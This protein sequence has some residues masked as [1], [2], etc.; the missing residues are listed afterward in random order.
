MVLST[1]LA[2][3]LI[4]V[5]PTGDKNATSARKKNCPVGVCSY[6][7]V[8]LE[9]SLRVRFPNGIVVEV[10]VI[11][12]SNNTALAQRHEREEKCYN[13]IPSRWDELFSQRKSC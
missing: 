11:N 6:L 3:A 5:R 8:R 13:I 2:L 9:R 7:A 4:I 10:V 1:T 12:I